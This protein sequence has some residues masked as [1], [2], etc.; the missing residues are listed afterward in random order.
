[1]PL[2]S[3]LYNWRISA[4]PASLLPSQRGATISSKRVEADQAVDYKASGFDCEV[5]ATSE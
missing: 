1:V 3:T 2:A 4:S 5:R